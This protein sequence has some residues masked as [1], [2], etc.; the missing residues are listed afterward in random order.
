MFDKFI[1]KLEKFGNKVTSFQTI[2]VIKDSFVDIMPIIIGGSFASL[3]NNV[4]CSPKNGLAQFNGFQFLEQFGSIFSAIN[5]ATMNMLAIYLVY[6][7]GYHAS[8]LRD[9]EPGKG[10]LIALA[11]YIILIPT[12]YLGTVGGQEVSITNVLRS[13]YTNSQGMFLALVVGNLSIAILGFFSKIDKLRIKMPDTV[14]AGVSNSF[15]VIIPAIIT[16]VIF[17]LTN[18]FINILLGTNIADLIYIVLQKPMEVVMQH[19]L[20]V[21]VLAILCSLFWLIGIHGSQLIGVVR[22]SIGLAAIAANLIAF[23]SGQP[24]PNIFTYTFW[25]TYVT[26]G[27]SGNTL[28]L[29]IAI[30]LVSKRSDVKSIAKLSLIPSFFGINE[31]L[32]FGLPIVLNPI[33]AIPFILAPTAGALIGYAAT[34]INFAGAAYITV[35]FTVPPFINAIITTGSI[36]TVI[37]QA[38]VIVVSTLIYLPFVKAMN[39]RED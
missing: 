33:L 10:G 34:Y 24:L 31:P 28:G 30:F 3:V 15:T 5:Y 21:V 20:G 36:G 11:S 27:G 18:W 8:K 23:E 25:N 7:V 14:P 1:Q 17:G 22:N 2:I 35:P 16:F 39:S 37:T 6:R 13:N 19:P 9:L 4:I 38:I 12:I 32:I 29:L 26:I